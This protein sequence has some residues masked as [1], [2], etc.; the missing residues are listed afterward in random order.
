MLATRPLLVYLLFD[1]LSNPSSNRTVTSS[2][3]ALTKACFDS[4][5]KSLRIL[6]ALRSQDLLGM[7]SWSSGDMIADRPPE[8]FHPFDIDSAQ[9]SAFVLLLI[10][11]IDSNGSTDNS[12]PHIEYAEYILDTMIQRGSVPAKHRSSELKVL[13]ELLRLLENRTARTDPAQSV[14]SVEKDRVPQNHVAN[15]DIVT[16]QG[17]DGAS[18]SQYANAMGDTGLSPDEMLEVARLLEWGNTFPEASM[19]MPQEQLWDIF[20][21]TVYE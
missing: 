20:G 21:D 3:K 12:M 19:T 2:I 11:T 13:Q 8:T 16:E 18:F 9:S 5:E 10:K 4:A 14:N 1:K 6:S 7:F 15:G 17:L